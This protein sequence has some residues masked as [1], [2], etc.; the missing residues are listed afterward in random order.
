MR[1]Y[2]QLVL[3]M[4]AATVLPLAVVGFL[5]LSRAEAALA[6]RIASEQRSL[7]EAS[8]EAVAEQL[9][10]T[11]EALARSAEMLPWEEASAQEAQG[12]LRLLYGQSPAVSAVVQVDAQGQPLG[13]PV[14]HEEAEGEHPPFN[15]ARLP[16]LLQSIQ[17]QA[18]RQGGKGATALGS[19]YAHKPDTRTAVGVAVKLEEGE[20]ARYAVAEVALSGVEA[21]L[22][23]RAQGRE[24]RVDLVNAQGLVL[25]SSEPA[26]WLGA[27]EAEVL[28]ALPAQGAQPVRSVR[29]GSPPLR[30]SMARVPQGLGLYVV[31][32]VGEAVALEPVHAMRR[33]VLASIGAGLAVLLALGG[34]FTR[35]LNRRLAAVVQG[36]EAYGRG[37]LDRRLPV[38]GEDE[39]SELATTFNRMGEELESARARI[40]RWNDELKARVEEATAELKAAQAQ[41][42]EAQKLAAI[43]QLG[44]GVAHEMNNP[45]AGILGN[46]Q[47]LLLERDDKDPDLESLKKIE[48]SARR[49]KE[50]TQNLLRFSQQSERPQLRPVDLNTVVKDALMLT[51]NQLRGEAITL[52]L[53]LAAAPVR[54]R[55][56]PGHLSQVVLAMVS[57]SRTAM[58]KADTKRLT[59]RTGEREGRGCLEVE[60]T[61]KGIA[62]E[63]RSRVFEPFFTT[64]DVWSNVGL[65]LSVAWRVVSEAGGTIEVR[66]EVGQGTCFTVWLPRVQ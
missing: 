60:D 65:G 49:C 3:F 38:Q 9:L 14:F 29:A 25:V 53:E 66:S 7:A 4:L 32:S 42:L 52:V 47:L 20:G 30:V 34:L 54:V 57:N 46:A 35:R 50:I 45:L 64:K 62:P 26:R 22:R 33:T 51:E 5:L 17:V 48:A 39:L 13:P 61:G 40:L 19:L 1:L 21:L 44:A 27:L 2:Q 28:A 16:V 12:A 43:G 36:A 41:L 8:A 56:D 24:G 10:S 18:L 58:L 11:V 63:L 59:L 15:P 37:E 23:R 55:A 6:E 31:V